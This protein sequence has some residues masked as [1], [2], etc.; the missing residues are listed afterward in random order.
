MRWNRTRRGFA[1]VTFQDGHD[2]E[3]II[4]KSSRVEDAIWIGQSKLIVKHFVPFRRPNAWEDVDIESLLGITKGSEQHIIGSNQ[5]HLNREQV[6]ELLPVL[7]RFVD[8]GDI[9]E[10]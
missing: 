3:C 6:A 7:Q 1:F 10:V 2:D 9:E 5:M 4:Q 8:T